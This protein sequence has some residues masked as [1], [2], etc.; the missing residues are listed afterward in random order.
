M[1][2]TIQPAQAPGKTNRCG[3]LSREELIELFSHLE[4][5]PLAGRQASVRCGAAAR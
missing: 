4:L 5:M 3:A 2:P 1:P